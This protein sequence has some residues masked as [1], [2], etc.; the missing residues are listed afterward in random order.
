MLNISYCSMLHFDLYNSAHVQVHNKT[1]PSLI[2]EHD[3]HSAWAQQSSSSSS[4]SSTLS[5]P[6]LLHCLC[7]LKGKNTQKCLQ[8]KKPHLY[9]HI[10]LRPVRVNGYCGYCIYYNVTPGRAWKCD[11]SQY[12]FYTCQCGFKKKKRS[13]R[14]VLPAH[15]AQTH[16]HTR[17]WWDQCVRT[18]HFHIKNNPHQHD[19]DK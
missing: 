13:G 6:S 12:C 19:S 2:R 1:G 18:Q 7:L 17:C 16:V 8:G 15:C 4:S 9:P 3:T 5:L 11:D 14:F 10:H